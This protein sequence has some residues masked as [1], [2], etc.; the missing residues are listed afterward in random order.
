[1]LDR[2]I[3]SSN[4]LTGSKSSAVQLRHALAFP[5]SDARGGVISIETPRLILNDLRENEF[6]EFYSLFTVKP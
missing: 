5:G 6:P 3:S 4:W 1:M 2:E